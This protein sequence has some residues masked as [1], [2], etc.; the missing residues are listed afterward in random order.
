MKFLKEWSLLFIICFSSFLKASADQAAEATPQ[1]EVTVE[2]IWNQAQLI[3]DLSEGHES[4]KNE[5]LKLLDLYTRFVDPLDPTNVR[6]NVE[7]LLKFFSKRDLMRYVTKARKL[8]KEKR[9]K[10]EKRE[11]EDASHLA[12]E[13]EF[14]G[15]EA[16]PTGGE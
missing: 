9:E 4:L 5:K 14:R 3:N 7:D 15:A 1:E 13:T 2:D 12:I 8:S 16:L 10:R 6:F 11:I